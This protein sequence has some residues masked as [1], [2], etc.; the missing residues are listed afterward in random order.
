MARLLPSD[1]SPQDF[2][3]ASE[4]PTAEALG[5]GL[6]DSWV[7]IHG[8]HWTLPTRRRLM[9]GEIDFVVISPAGA[10]V[11]IEQ[12][13]GSVEYEGGELSKA[14]GGQTKS[15]SKQMARNRESF[16]RKLHRGRVPPPTGCISVGYFPDVR[17]KDVQD[18]AL[19]DCC[20]VDQGRADRLPRVIEELIGGGEP[21]PGKVAAIVSFLEGALDLVPSLHGHRTLADR[22][23]IQLSGPMRVVLENFEMQPMRLRIEACAGSGKSELLRVLAR[24]SVAAGRR[25]LLTC[26]N[27]PLADLHRNGLPGA[28][29]ET[30]FSLRRNLAEALGIELRFPEKADWVFWRQL[31][32]ETTE[33]LGRLEW[34]AEF[35]YD[36]IFVDE[37]QDLADEDIDQLLKLLAP[38][39]DFVWVGDPEQDLMERAA[40]RHRGH[41]VLR[42]LDNYRTPTR[43]AA[44]LADVAPSGVRFLNPAEGSGLEVRQLRGGEQDLTEALERE[45]AQLLR[46]GLDLSDLMVIGMQGTSGLKPLGD[47]IGPYSLRRFTGGYTLEGEQVMTSGSLLAESVARA[48]G[49]Q[50]AHALVLGGNASSMGEP[51]WRRAL[52][53]ALTRATV[54]ATLFVDMS[55]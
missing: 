9:Q 11:L 4:W 53:V 2:E 18:I 49:K 3:N 38:D 10:V 43:L 28:T 22:M 7:V 41:A 36:S 54:G 16:L 47:S 52:Y 32:E 34:P 27:R 37:G 25:T 46:K 48:K 6:P 39:G 5:Q 31:E 33:A 44:E 51:E 30:W 29:V 35:L 8:C 42:V 55:R 15:V 21:E 17:I 14:Y 20:L 1:L 24:R 23:R 13:N 40:G 50:C 45:I 26:F 12:K 19:D